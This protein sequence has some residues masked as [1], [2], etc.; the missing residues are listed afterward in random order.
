MGTHNIGLFRPF[1]CHISNTFC[2]AIVKLTSVV[3]LIGHGEVPTDFSNESA[4]EPSIIHIYIKKNVDV[5]VSVDYQPTS[6]ENC[7]LLS[8]RP[9]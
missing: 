5:L 4:K 7:L 9:Q 6:L 3:L 2:R 8:L 1:L